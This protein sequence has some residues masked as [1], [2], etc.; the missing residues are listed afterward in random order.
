MNKRSRRWWLVLRMFSGWFE[1][2]VRAALILSRSAAFGGV[3]CRERPVAW[4]AECDYVVTG[5]ERTDGAFASG[6]CA[7]LARW[8]PGSRGRFRTTGIPSSVYLCAQTSSSLNVA[9]H[10]HCAESSKALRQHMCLIPTDTWLLQPARRPA[11]RRS[12]FES[13][14]SSNAKLLWGEVLLP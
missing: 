3:T 11:A 4:R 6:G 2:K 10:V 1:F 12:P 13:S 9:Q 8:G 7:C 5:W 14:S